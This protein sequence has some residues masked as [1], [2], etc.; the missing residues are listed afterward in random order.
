MR[1]VGDGGRRRRGAPGGIPTRIAPVVVGVERLQDPHVSPADRQEAPQ[2][3]IELGLR[4]PAIQAR[5]PKHDGVRERADEHD[6]IVVGVL[7]DEI[8]LDRAMGHVR[9]FSRRRSRHVRH[10]DLCM[11]GARWT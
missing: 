5:D 7:V 4:S 3:A 9:L 1:S 8:S 6:R 10:A 11:K 2:D